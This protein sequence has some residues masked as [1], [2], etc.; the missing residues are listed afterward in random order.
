M[1]FVNSSQLIKIFKTDQCLFYKLN[2]IF[3]KN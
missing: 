2:I 3:P 1:K